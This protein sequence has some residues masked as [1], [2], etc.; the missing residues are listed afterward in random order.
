MRAR[1]RTVAI[2]AAVALVA[3]IAH[4]A[5]AAAAGADDLPFASALFLSTHNSFSGNIYGGTRGSI[6]QQLDAGVRFVELDIHD[7]HFVDIGDYEVG[8]A[9]PGS[10]VDYTGNPQTN[11]LR[12][13]L[14]V[15]ANWSFAHPTHALLVVMLDVKDD[16][17]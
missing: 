6:Q 10:E 15:V 2:L 14:Q 1:V 11:A 7:D 3:G 16:L 12:P 17:T 5:P 4:A 8:H 13:W 9:G